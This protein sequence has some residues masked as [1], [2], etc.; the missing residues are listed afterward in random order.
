MTL[1]WHLYRPLVSST[2]PRGALENG[3]IL[4]WKCKPH[5][6]VKITSCYTQS[7]PV[8]FKIFIPLE[9]GGSKKQT[10]EGSK[11]KKISLWDTLRFRSLETSRTYTVS[12]IETLEGSKKTFYSKLI[13]NSRILNRM[14]FWKLLTFI[15]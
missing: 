5:V 2:L 9:Y 8:K 7:L 14:L 4:P 6:G 10:L 1:A 15:F 12:R 13:E 3:K 11:N